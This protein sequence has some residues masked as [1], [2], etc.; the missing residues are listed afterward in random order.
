[1]AILFWTGF[2]FVWGALPFSYWIARSVGNVD[3][4]ETYDGNP[5]AANVF[6]AL[7]WRWGALALV[8][9]WL[10]GFGPVFLALYLGNVSG[11][12][13]VPVAL[14]PVFGHAW[15]PF[16]R[17]RGGKALATSFG[18]WTSLTLLPGPF[19]LGGLLTIF[20]LVQAN[21]GWTVVFA[22]LAFLFFLLIWDPSAPLLSVWA[23]NFLVLSW[24]YR[25]ELRLGIDFRW[26]PASRGA[27]HG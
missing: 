26:V 16:L 2:G 24:K 12:G 20:L 22:M 10:K 25:H 27:R 9:D 23:A 18:I 19:V 4:R 7:G 13:I 1:M 5:G 15:S 8:L 21:H 3:I 11:W 14:A 17:L 6:R